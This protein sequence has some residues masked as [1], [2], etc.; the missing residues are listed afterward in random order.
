MHRIARRTRHPPPAE[1]GIDI[2]D[3]RG[4]IGR[5][6][7]RRPRGEQEGRGKA[8]H[9]RPR[10]GIRAVHGPD[11]PEISGAVL[12]PGYIGLRSSTRNR[13]G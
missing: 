11:A 13:S 7:Q 9:R 4:S 10:S 1:I 5:R 6:D 2:I 3:T 12:Q 8:P